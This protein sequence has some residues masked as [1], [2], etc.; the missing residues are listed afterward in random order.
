MKPAGRTGGYDD[1]PITPMNKSY[2]QIAD[3]HADDEESEERNFSPTRN[4]SPMRT[5]DGTL[6]NARTM[7]ASQRS[8]MNSMSQTINPRVGLNAK[9]NLIDASPSKTLGAKKPSPSTDSAERRP[10][11]E[12]RKLKSMNLMSKKNITDCFLVVGTLKDNP[13]NDAFGPQAKEAKIR[14]LRM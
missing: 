6:K 11:N 7:S 9:Q 3:I 4:R 13:G 10:G 5:K 1:R 12:R 2:A 14:N 8:T